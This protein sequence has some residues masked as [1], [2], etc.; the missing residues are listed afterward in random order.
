M[1]TFGNAVLNL[2][3]SLLLIAVLVMIGR[4]WRAAT[5]PERR[6]VL[7]IYAAGAIV[8]VSLTLSLLVQLLSLPD[9]TS[10]ALFFIAAMAF[11]LLPFLFLAGL[12]RSRCSPP[13]R[14]PT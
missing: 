5:R 12:I 3:G 9:G 11:G 14:S 8:L 10:D 13:A 1:D 6:I 7:P 4:R 2:S